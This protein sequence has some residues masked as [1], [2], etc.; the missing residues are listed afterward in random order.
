MS[1]MDGTAGSTLRERCGRTAAVLEA[2]RAGA[3]EAELSRHAAQCPI[4]ADALWIE[5]L[6]VE[7]AA[8]ARE[9]APVSDPG[10][11]WHRVRAEESRAR[12]ARALERA[13][14]PIRAARWLAG[15]GGLAAAGW[16]IA[17]I[18]PAAHAWL[19]SLEPS[20][21]LP[22]EL[23]ALAAP[24]LDAQTWLLLAAMIGLTAVVSGLYLSWSEM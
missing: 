8:A 16:G 3:L 12:S 22:A 6:M 2:E 7:D 13:L 23:E 4:C 10:A 11:L 14:W 20:R 15:A 17:R 18:A 19:G 1:R 9:R 24:E 5:R 21:W